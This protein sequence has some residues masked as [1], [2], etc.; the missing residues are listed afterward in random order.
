[1]QPNL[2]FFCFLV[3]VFAWEEGKS[4]KIY[5]RPVLSGIVKFYLIKFS[6]L[7]EQYLELE[8]SRLFGTLHVFCPFAY[9]EIE[10]VFFAGCCSSGCRFLLLFFHCSYLNYLVYSIPIFRAIQY[11]TA[12]CFWEHSFL[13]RKEK[14][15]SLLFFSTL[16]KR[17]HYISTT[18]V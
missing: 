11:D 18:L 10:I 3:F 13:Q 12:Y 7:C 6:P 17:K 1:M 8:G 5:Y 14:H 4:Q 9:L 16:G 2:T 15:T